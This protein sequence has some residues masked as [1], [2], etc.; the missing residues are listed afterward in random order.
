[1]FTERKVFVAFDK[2]PVAD[3]RFTG[4]SDRGGDFCVIYQWEERLRELSQG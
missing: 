1:M 2:W 3:L 4:D